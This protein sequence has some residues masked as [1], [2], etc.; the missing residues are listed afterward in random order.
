[1]EIVYSECMKDQYIYNSE[2]Y[3]H[4]FNRE[5]QIGNNLH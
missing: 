1:M 5:K 3:S 2:K 4:H